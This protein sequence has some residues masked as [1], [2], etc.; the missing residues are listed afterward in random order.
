MA[1]SMAAFW[2]S[3]RLIMSLKLDNIRFQD[4]GCELPHEIN[5]KWR[6]RQHSRQRWIPGIQHNAEFHKRGLF[7]IPQVNRWCNCY[8]SSI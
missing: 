3:S 2:F 7:L 5:V 8:P 6:Y 1:R 4:T